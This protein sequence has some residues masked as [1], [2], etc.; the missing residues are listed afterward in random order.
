MKSV[1]AGIIY[2]AIMLTPLI[3]PVLVIGAG[4]WL[5]SKLIG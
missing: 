1:A 2:V 5:G 3:V 4:I